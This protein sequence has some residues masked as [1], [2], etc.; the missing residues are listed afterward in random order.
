MAVMKRDV[1]F[2]LFMLII[3]TLIVFAGFSTYY[4]RSFKN[5]TSDYESKLNELNEITKNLE[6]KKTELASTQAE[7][8]KLSER[9][10]DLSQRYTTLDELKEQLEDDKAALEKNLQEAQT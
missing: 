6:T 5:V 2:G 10:A 4:Q 9:E 3:A 7:R 1:N 8:E